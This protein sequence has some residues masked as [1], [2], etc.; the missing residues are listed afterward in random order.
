ME[1]RIDSFFKSTFTIFLNDLEL[2]I[3]ENESLTTLNNKRYILFDRNWCENNVSSGEN[4][5]NLNI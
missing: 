5:I 3:V 4:N 1:Y 2:P